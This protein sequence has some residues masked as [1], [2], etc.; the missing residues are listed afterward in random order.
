MPRNLGHTSLR[1]R[2]RETRSMTEF[3]R[4]PAELR[5]WLATAVLPWSPR[6]ARQAY[7]RAVG[8][9]RNKAEA[10]EELDRVQRRLIQ[11]DARRI[12]GSEHPDVAAAPEP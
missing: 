2:R 9:T 1:R 5:L 8:R 3:D 11:R 4:L 12:W 10:L 7:A 6:S